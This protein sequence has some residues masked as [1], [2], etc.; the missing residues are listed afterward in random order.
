MQ[1]EILTKIAFSEDEK[2]IKDSHYDVYEFNNS[3]QLQEIIDISICTT[4]NGNCKQLFRGYA[5]RK[6]FDK[7]N[8]F[9]LN[10]GCKSK[11]LY[12]L[13]DE[14]KFQWL[15]ATNAKK[16]ETAF[17]YHL[18]RQ[19]YNVSTQE[20]K[21]LQ[22]EPDDN[23]NSITRCL[24]YTFGIEFETAGGVIPEDKCFRYGLVPLR[25]GSITG[26]EY[27]TVP[28]TNKHI[29]TLKTQVQCLKKYT[30]FNDTC[31]MHMHFG[32]LPADIKFFYVLY[33]VFSI[34]EDE[35]DSLLPEYTFRTELYKDNEKSYC[36][37]LP[38]NFNIIDWYDWLSNGT[39]L[40]NPD[41]TTISLRTA[42]PSDPAGNHKWNIAQRYYSLNFINALFYNR[43]KTVE[44][45]FLKPSNN[46]NYIINWLY[47]FTAILKYTENIYNQ[48]NIRHH[49]FKECDDII[50]NVIN[51][52]VISLTT[53]I[54]AAFGDTTIS[55]LLLSFLRNLQTVTKLQKY[56][57]DKIGMKTEFHDIYFK[58]NPV[59]Q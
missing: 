20:I 29:N 2:A 4:H 54:Y 40:L 39:V 58:N 7:K 1:L 33:R 34:L 6:I 23:V 37:K 30:T 56:I 38:K 9:Y 55:K 13:G 5:L 35:L 16:L 25:D 53:C 41:D 21:F 42:H 47:L 59:D 14:T 15:Q 46:I 24:K 27:A 32:R 8:L 49:T 11:Y 45:R 26:V 36:R 44:F 48:C 52:N 31:S 10:L 57:G 28:L 19:F 3:K 22:P 43:N 17:P 51:T 50:T 18:V 12:L